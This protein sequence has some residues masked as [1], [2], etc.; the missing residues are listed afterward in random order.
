MSARFRVV[1]SIS[2]RAF[3]IKPASWRPLL[4]DTN[5]QTWAPGDSQLPSK[6]GTFEFVA[7]NTDAQDLINNKAATFMAYVNG[8]SMIKAGIQDKDILI[9]S[10]KKLR[11]L[12]N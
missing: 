12:I 9:K 8:T 7:V 6:V 11:Q 2:C 10:I 3:A 1:W 4:E 5:E